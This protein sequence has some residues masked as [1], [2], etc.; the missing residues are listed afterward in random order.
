MKSFEK[1]NYLAINKMSEKQKSRAAKNKALSKSYREVKRLGGNL[2]SLGMKAYNSK[3][4][5]EAYN[6]FFKEQR[7][8][9]LEN[10]SR[11]QLWDR[12][13]ELGYEIRY[14]NSNIKELNKFIRDNQDRPI[15]VRVTI[16][17]ARL[18][19]DMT[20]R[21]IEKFDLDKL[22]I[23][24]KTFIIRSTTATLDA[25]I[26]K[27]IQRFK[28]PIVGYV[29]GSNEDGVFYEVITEYNHETT[30]TLP[31]YNALT[32][33]LKD[34]YSPRLV[35]FNN[36]GEILTKYINKLNDQCVIDY[37]YD[38]YILRYSQ[39]KKLG[40]LNN[41]SRIP[42][43]TKE[44]IGEVISD[45]YNEENSSPNRMMA[46]PVHSWCD[47]CEV[48]NKKYDAL[49]DG[50]NVYQLELFCKKYSISLRVC[51][52]DNRCF[53]SCLCQ[54]NNG[55]EPM[56]IIS[57]N[58][59]LYPIVDKKFRK[60]LGNSGR[61]SKNKRD[62][63][64]NVEVKQYEK[65]VPEKY[66]KISDKL[67]CHEILDLAN[68]NPMTC[69]V[70]ETEKVKQGDFEMNILQSIWL[71]LLCER[72]EYYQH[73]FKATDMTEIFLPNKCSLVINRDY[74]KVMDCCSKSEIAFENQSL[75]KISNDNFKNY[76]SL[77]EISSN[78]NKKTYE[79]IKN[80]MPVGNWVEQYWKA[81]GRLEDHVALDLNKLYSSIL[82]DSN[83]EWIK[84]D[85]TSQ[86]TKFSGVFESNKLYYVNTKRQLL[87]NQGIGWY[88]PD[89]VHIGLRDGLIKLDDILYEIEGD[90]K[91]YNFNKFVEYVYETFGN[92]L[93]K[94]LLNPF[95][96][97]LGKSHSQIGNQ[98]WTTSLEHACT[99]FCNQTNDSF[100]FE[101]EHKGKT[102]YC[103]ENSK[104]NERRNQTLLIHRQIVQTGWIKVYNLIKDVGGTLISVNTDCIVV[105]D[106][107]R[108]KIRVSK[109]RG[110]YKHEKISPDRWKR[111]T[112]SDGSDSY[113]GPVKLRRTE[114]DTSQKPIPKIFVEDEWN[115]ASV[116]DT[117]IKDNK[118]VLL[119]GRAGCGKTLVTQELIKQLRTDGK[120]VKCGAP[121]HVA[122]RL[123]DEQAQTVHGLFGHDIIGKVHTVKFNDKQVV[124]IDEV[125][126]MSISFWREIVKLRRTQPDIIFILV[127]DF[128]QL[129]AIGEEHID[130]YKSE[131]FRD[132]VDVH[133]D[134]V[135][136]KRCTEDGKLH[137]DI[138]TSAINGERINYQ[139]PSADLLDK[140]LC[141]TNRTRVR[142]NE[143][144]MNKYSL[145]ID[146]SLF[147]PTVKPEED[148]DVFTY[149]D[150]WI[151]EGL[152]VRCKKNHTVSEL[153]LYN[154]DMLVV[155]SYDDKQITLRRDYDDKLIT[156]TN[157]PDFPY[158]F[159]PNYASTIHSCQGQTFDK[160][161]C[162]HEYHKYD[163]RLLYVALSRTTNL[164]NIHI[165]STKLFK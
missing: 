24:Q 132:I 94:E 127:G 164:K 129:R 4:A 139:F 93:G 137:Y 36:D 69:F 148:E 103:M 62:K 89:L 8:L 107:I 87:F 58:G 28:E 63:K 59:H 3:G 55:I 14:R 10:A 65:S 75:L 101:Q 147:I 1:N 106:P 130:V 105:K 78:F 39:N 95:I 5:E 37:I 12:A 121:T 88:F 140:N 141:Y 53:H 76:S 72:N 163:C 35:T 2:E 133:L 152:P 151:Y 117:I 102:V 16:H 50:V 162:L 82:E 30:R 91:Y 116:V 84:L 136:N 146:D 29:L 134:L 113:W 86:V 157:V 45:L 56:M 131:F 165:A 27:L 42:Y 54:K 47:G 144:L 96:G 32:I 108:K 51:D 124:V 66:Q 128:N 158:V 156:I 123:M 115:T 145:F 160:E 18:P 77:E 64:G 19:K 110:G 154:G 20:S 71:D 33:P 67:T 143:R 41:K 57:T 104:L 81:S 73:G 92:S 126:M 99:Q 23:I 38:D 46:C 25:N 153:R 83:M 149:Q 111:L 161:Y 97:N 150:M 118:N 61:Y 135:E 60:S 159:Y 74:D 13:K 125:S 52:K 114:Y 68:E 100:V 48:C 22:S 6:N 26:E 80:D 85:I 34:R 11:K 120:L 15:G 142:L 17:Y 43:M 44:K 21:E 70:F 49:I 9:G 109:G 7:A 112:S 90:I 122:R 79:C 40:I 155:K 138:M 98:K 31:Q 119:T